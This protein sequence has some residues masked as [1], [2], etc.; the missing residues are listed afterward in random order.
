MKAIQSIW[1]KPIFENQDSIESRFSGGWLSHLAF[2]ASTAYSAL[3]IKQ[4]YKRLELVTDSLGKKIFADLLEIPYDEV[5]VALDFLSPYDVSLWSLGKI[6]ACAMQQ[7]PFIHFDT[8]LFIWEK[9]PVPERQTN[10]TV[11]QNLECACE[12]YPDLVREICV[13]FGYVPPIV[14]QLQATAEINVYNTGIIGSSDPAFMQKFAEAAF[15]FVDANHS[16]LAKEGNGLYNIIFEQ[17]FLTYLAKEYGQPVHC[18]SPLTTMQEMDQQFKSYQHFV[19]APRS[20]RYIHL[21]GHD[22]KMQPQF[23]AAILKRLQLEYPA[24]YE[25]IVAL[26]L[27]DLLVLTQ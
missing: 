4:H 10:W 17:L 5:Q 7:E 25:R 14:R 15:Q 13:K 9:I 27:E 11:V 19:E 2:F 3:Q 20:A 12:M 24:A 22:C 1:T 18:Y 16:Q 21:Y 26:K 6:K 8:D 23:C